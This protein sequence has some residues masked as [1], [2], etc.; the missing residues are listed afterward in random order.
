[1]RAIAEQNVLIR[2]QAELPAD[3]KM[4]TE[5]FRNGW[6]FTRS[7]NAQRLKKKIEK[8]GWNLM[9]NGAGCERSG[10]GQTSQMAVTA[11]LALA[12]RRLTVDFNAAEIE[13]IQLTQ[14]PWFFLARVI[15]HP[16]R[17]QESAAFPFREDTG[18]SPVRARQ[19]SMP[20]D[21]AS[22]HPLFAGA[23]SQL[24]DLLVVS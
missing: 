14:Y 5:V 1:M 3:F 19:G 13:H 21:Q 10:V 11:A 15:I 8:H 20:A 12:L 6:C 18:F 7:A 17:I 22:L 24:K 2:E 9:K 4:A 23:M 16:Y